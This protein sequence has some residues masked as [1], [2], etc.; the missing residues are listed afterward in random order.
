M[1]YQPDPINSPADW[2]IA[3]LSGPEPR[4]DAVTRDLLFESY[5]ELKENCARGGLLE[6]ASLGREVP[7]L[8]RLTF[9]T[10]GL[11]RRSPDHEVERV[12]PHV[13]ALRFLPDYLRRANR[14]QMLRVIAPRTPPPFHPNISPVG[15]VCVEI[16]PGESLL[17]ICLSLHD[18]IRW[19]L[20]QYDE[21]DALNRP[22][23]AWGRE[24]VSRAI[25]DRPLFGRRIEFKLQPIG[26]TR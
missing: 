17:E 22:A 3:N 15:A 25:D 18:L 7:W 11:A 23:C 6:F 16:Y 13:V 4:F 5:R 21:R 26:D 19:R 14:F 20:R 9:H 12:T 2:M 8:Y 10:I 1:T 24:H